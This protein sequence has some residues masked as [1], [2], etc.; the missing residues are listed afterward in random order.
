MT[1]VDAVKQERD[2][3]KKAH[4]KRELTRIC[5]HRNRM[6]FAHYLWVALWS[7]WFGFYFYLPIA[8]IPMYLYCRPLIPVIVVL[9][10]TS[11]FLPLKR[12]LQPKWALKLGKKLT[13][14]AADYFHLEIWC[15]D[16]KAVNESGPAIWSIE[17]HD[18]LPC[19]IFAMSDYLGYFPG[20]STIACL[21]GAI[22]K[23]PLMRHVF[24]WTRAGSVD[25]KYLQRLLDQ[26]ISPIVC[27]GGA[28]EVTFMTTEPVCNMYI[29]QRMGLV[30]LAM[31]YGVPIIPTITYHGNDAY[32]FYV[33]QNK[34]VQKWS[35][36]LGFVP[37]VIL[38]MFN[39]PFAQP[40][41]TPL[42]VIVGVPIA[43]PKVE[44]KPSDELLA[45]YHTQFVE[46]T[47]RLYEDHKAQF[48]VEHMKL[49]IL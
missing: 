27:P 33:F 20:H 7:G 41:S 15:E 19:G 40:K 29:K 3:E 22:F 5:D 35:R 6:T 38:G 44:G 8:L 11:N 1:K 12:K 2:E 13:E 4:P 17:P 34:T 10:L 48:G 31:Q 23:V 49:N 36:R 14:C 30:K 26:K 16:Y 47:R 43:I 21:T 25:K 39:I 18:V 9:I 46:A 28:M 45:K 24:T 32:D 37:V 42:Q